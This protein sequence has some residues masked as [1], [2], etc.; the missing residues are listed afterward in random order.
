[1]IRTGSP[2]Q[3]CSGAQI[4]MPIDDAALA[5]ALLQRVLPMEK[6]PVLN[7]VD[8]TDEPGRQTQASVKQHSP[9]FQ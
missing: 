8:T 2:S 6:K 5:N 7:A 9:I 3:I 1:M 4:A